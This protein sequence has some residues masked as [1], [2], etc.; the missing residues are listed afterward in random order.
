MGLY[1]I[2]DLH[3]SFLCNKPMDIF[4]DEWINHHLKLEEGW[5]AQVSGDDTVIIPGDISW[6]MRLEEAMDDLEFIHR[7]PGRKVLSKGNHDYWWNSTDKLN[8]LF[9]DMI[10]LKNSFVWYEDHAICAAKGWICPRDTWSAPTFKPEDEKVFK[11]E[12]VR[13]GL[14]LSKAKNAGAEKIILMLHYPPCPEIFDDEAGGFAEKPPEE[15]DFM[16]IIKEYPVEKIIYGHIH[17]ALC[18]EQN[19][20]R[21]FHGIPAQLAA[22]DY[23][24]FKPVRIL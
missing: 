24:E 10:F 7:L 17:G 4:G 2:S 13:L 21:T 12:R 16:D 3:L 9:K 15:S 22:A 18:F 11:R 8:G 20:C 19:M 6:G 1:A 5:R 23:L 14:S